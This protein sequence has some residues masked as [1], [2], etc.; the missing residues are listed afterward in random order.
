MYRINS[1]LC[2]FNVIILVLFNVDY[3]KFYS[4][5]SYYINGKNIKHNV[6]KNKNI[7]Y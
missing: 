4:H 7:I 3:D 5:L 2:K 1:C 6:T